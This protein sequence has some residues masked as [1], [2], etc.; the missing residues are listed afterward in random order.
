MMV[1]KVIPSKPVENVAAAQECLAS[2]ALA[3]KE[4]MNDSLSK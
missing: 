1:S 2:C 4:R 3:A